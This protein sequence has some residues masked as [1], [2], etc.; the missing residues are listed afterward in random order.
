MGDGVGGWKAG[1]GSLNHVNILGLKKSITKMS[2]F[3]RNLIM[4][5]LMPKKNFQINNLLSNNSI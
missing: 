2:Y 1:E 3:M 5:H 4:F